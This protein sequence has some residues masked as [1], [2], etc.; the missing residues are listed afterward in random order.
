MRRFAARSDGSPAG[1]WRVG[2]AALAA[3]LALPVLWRTFFPAPAFAVV[4]RDLVQ[5]QVA[6]LRLTHA[7]PGM[8]ERADLKGLDAAAI[9]RAVTLA[10]AQERLPLMDRRAVLSTAGAEPLDLTEAVFERLG[11]TP[12][13]RAALADALAHGW[14]ADVNLALERA[15]G[16]SDPNASRGTG[17]RLLAE[18]G[19][20]EADPPLPDAD[21]DFGARVKRLLKTIRGEAADGAQPHTDN[22]G[23]R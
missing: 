4:D 1:L 19:R 9:D 12:A 5:T 15:G 10:A 3:A 7:Q 21:Q 6:L 23:G 13:D 20:V 2:A 8:P 11:V 22:Q 17:G 18:A 16:A 14:T